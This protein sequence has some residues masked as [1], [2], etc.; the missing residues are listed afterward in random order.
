VQ[1]SDAPDTP[2]L[3]LPAHALLQ[4]QPAA[5]A[6]AAGCHHHPVQ[7]LQ[8]HLLLLLLCLLE[9]GMPQLS[10]ALHWI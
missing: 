2:S 3:Q 4:K 9:L 8:R 5:L 7:H 1:Q 6:H 10:T